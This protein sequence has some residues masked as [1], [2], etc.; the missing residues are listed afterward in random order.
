MLHLPVLRAGVPYRSLNLNVLTDVRNGEPVAEVSQANRGLLSRDLLRMPEHRAALRD[1]ETEELIEKCGVAAGLFHDGDLPL[2]PGGDVLQSPEDFVRS[3]SATTGMPE[4][5]CR[6][7]MEKIRFVMAEM[8]RVL[9]G[10]TRGVDLGVLDRGFC[11]EGGRT[12]SYCGEADAL[13][14]VLPSNSPGVHSLWIPSVA[15]KVPVV[16]KPG[17]QEPWTPLRIAN[18]L[19]AA[20][21]PAATVGFYPADHSCGIEILLRTDRSML[22]GDENTVRAWRRDSRV[23]LHGPGWSKV[24]FGADRAGEW[25]EHLDLVEASVAANG[26]RSCVNASGVWTTDHGDALA[27][28]LAERLVKTEARPL[29]DP[30]AGIAA[31]SNPQVAHRISEFIDCQLG[32]PGAEDV[33]ARFR[34]EGRIAE[35]DGCTF[36]LPTV[37]RCNDPG[38]PLAASELLFPFVSV[39]EMDQG[40]L[41]ESIGPTLVAS[42]ISDD[43][44]L[45]R[46]LMIAR[47][48]DRLNLGALPTNVVSWDQPHEGNLFE[49]LYR[50][51]AYQEEARAS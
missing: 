24:I 39:V 41:A 32:I 20:G 27:E 49:H 43:P 7:N 17:S 16:L 21:F 36:L 48:V 2:E 42:L 6:A 4:A 11:T 14:A 37:I 1:L 50:Q 25:E 5:L 44:A 23:Q 15:L 19:L 45:R 31:F 38:H 29:D 35:L 28:G 18:A 9:A 12:V 33:T 3:Q 34:P 13:G 10:L 8:R 46:E 30:Q 47:H 22:F 51:R 26:G 40:R